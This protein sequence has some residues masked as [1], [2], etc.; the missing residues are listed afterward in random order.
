MTSEEKKAYMQNYLFLLNKIKKTE[1]SKFMS[2]EEN[3]AEIAEIAQVEEKK[4]K[5]KR[6]KM[7]SKLQVKQKSPL[8]A[9]SESE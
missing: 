1:R 5:R 4:T 3:I 8:L 9:K 7:Q 6:K 2:V